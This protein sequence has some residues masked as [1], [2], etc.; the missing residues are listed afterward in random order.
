LF[1]KILIDFFLDFSFYCFGRSIKKNKSWKVFGMPYHVL[2]TVF[3]ITWKKKCELK[4][5][6]IGKSL[7][8]SKN[9]NKHIILKLSTTNAP[10]I[11]I[12]LTPSR[13]QTPLNIVRQY[14]NRYPFFYFLQ[15]RVYIGTFCLLDGRC[16]YSTL[17]DAVCSGARF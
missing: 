1:C 13:R 14:G 11:S 16:I 7:S 15:W 4:S 9:L 5:L 8:F 3:A 12:A 6:A 2:Y 17:F 10:T